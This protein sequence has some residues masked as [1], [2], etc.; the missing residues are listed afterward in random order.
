MKIKGTFKLS[1]LHISVED[2]GIGGGTKQM[3]VDHLLS[4]RR[5]SLGQQMLERWA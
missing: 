3:A 1:T 5:Q 2:L 4:E